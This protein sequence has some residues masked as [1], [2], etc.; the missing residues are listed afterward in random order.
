MFSVRKVR[1]RPFYR[2]LDLVHP[3]HQ[4]HS[5]GDEGD[6]ATDKRG[7]FHTVG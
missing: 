2:R 5:T 4:Y 1:S 7:E 3:V 6:L